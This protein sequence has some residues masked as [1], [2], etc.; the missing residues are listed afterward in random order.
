MC[1]CSRATRSDTVSRSGG[2]P[3]SGVAGRGTGGEVFK[4]ISIGAGPAGSRVVSPGVASGTEDRASRADA[5]GAGASSGPMG[6]IGSRIPRMGNG[7]TGS[8][9]GWYE[10]VPPAERGR[11]TGAMS[12]VR[13]RS[14]PG[15]R[16]VTVVRAARLAC[17]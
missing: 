2:D 9:M 13:G 1:G 5:K 10:R 15:S 8:G 11:G 4:G 3:G 16:T 17:R 12:G 6:V 7:L 14:V